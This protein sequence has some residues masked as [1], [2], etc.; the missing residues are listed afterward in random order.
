MK[1]FKVKEFIEILGDWNIIISDFNKVQC[2]G[3]E[4]IYWEGV[5]DD[6]FKERPYGDYDVMHITRYNADT[7]VIMIDKE[8]ENQTSN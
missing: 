1:K 5:T 8:V 3:E 7:M 2:N 6:Y 4:I